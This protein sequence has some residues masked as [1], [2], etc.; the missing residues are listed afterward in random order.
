[1]PVGATFS[2][3][4]AGAGH[5]VDGTMLL[6]SSMPPTSVAIATGGLGRLGGGALKHNT[7]NCNRS[8]G[9]FSGAVNRDIVAAVHPHFW[10]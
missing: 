3:G 5:H 6:G 7:G 2:I 1:M 9:V 10:H 4:Q 8:A